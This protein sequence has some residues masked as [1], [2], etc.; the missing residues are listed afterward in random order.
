MSGTRAD[1]ERFRRALEGEALPAMVIDLDALEFNAQL[2]L[3]KLSGTSPT[4]R[5]ATKSIRV[6]GIL[7]RL[8]GL[9]AGRFRGLMTYSAKETATLAGEGFDDL[10]L[11]YPIGR[12]IEANLLA[13]CV[14]AGTQL[15][16]V[17]DGP[18]QVR[19]LSDAA[20]ALGV[21]IKVCIDVDVSWRPLRGALHFGVRRSPIRSVKD[22]VGLCE[23]IERVKGVQL[24]GLLA[25]EAQVAGIR[26]TNPTSRQLDPVRRLVKR[27]SVPHAASLR[28]EIVAALK[29][30]GHALDIVNGGGSGSL[31]TTPSDRSVT[32]VTAGSGFFCP[33]LFDHYDGLPFR[34]AALFAMAVTRHSDPDH[35][36]AHGGGYVAS[37][38][39]GKD[40]LPEVYLPP[41]IEPL[42]LE[43]FGEVQT[44]FK[45]LPGAPELRLGDPILCR[46]AKS[47]ELAER[48]SEAWLIV[49]DRIVE[50]I[51]TY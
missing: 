10:L 2:A 17:V 8:Q 23:V 40:R 31:G 4:L 46:H 15:W 36:T 16:V 45:L 13:H 37:G 12:P 21:Q 24:R 41:D 33:H 30:R 34:P 26:E 5:I 49:G 25:Y 51:P 3:Q 29:A 6:P 11:A 47:G 1:W 19:L 14:A 22:A 18:D 28:S 38:P 44:P 32:E 9:G 43:G 48:F 39:A 7:K 50:R 42:D 35:V 20:T 27:Q